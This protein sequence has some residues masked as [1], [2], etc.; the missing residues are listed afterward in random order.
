MKLTFAF[1]FAGLLT[2]PQ[3]LLLF[4]LEVNVKFEN[5]RHN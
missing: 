4:S 2:F 3:N 1:A 5:F